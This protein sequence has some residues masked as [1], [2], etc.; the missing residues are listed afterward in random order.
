VDKQIEEA[1][2]Q[3]AEL[4]Q[5]TDDEFSA[6]MTDAQA[7]DYLNSAKDVVH[8]K[9]LELKDLEAASAMLQADKQVS[10][11]YWNQFEEGLV[12]NKDGKYEYN[13]A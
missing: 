9:E 3:L 11:S 1:K 6:Q 12:K 5:G 2:E 10:Q 4:T 7:L 8:T 13:P